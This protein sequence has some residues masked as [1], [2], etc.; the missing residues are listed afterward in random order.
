MKLLPIVGIDNTSHDDALT[1]GGKSPAYFMRDIVNFDISKRGSA[2]LRKSGRKVSPNIYLKVWQSPLHQ[3]VFAVDR[4]G[5]LLKIDPYSWE[6][7]QLGQVGHDVNFEVINNQ[8]FISASLGIFTFNGAVLTKITSDAPGYPYL[9][10]S[11][12]S[13]T[14]GQYGVAISYLRGTLESEL[15]RM[16]TISL[17]SDGLGIQVVLPLLKGEGVTGV[18]IYCTSGNGTELYLQSTHPADAVDVTIT[19]E[20]ELGRPASFR[21]FSKMPTGKFMTHW[22]GRLIT[23]DKNML[24]FSQSLTYH[25]TDPRYD[26]IRMPQSITF[27]IGVD[28]GLWVGQVDKVVFL[29]GNAPDTLSFEIK[30]AQPPVKGSA[31]TLDSEVTGE[32]GEGGGRTAMWLAANGLCIGTGSGGLIEPQSKRI[33]GI[34]AKSGG[35]VRFDRRVIATIK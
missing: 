9:Q 23:A 24:Y 28:G 16:E 32:L 12:G 19:G 26:Y 8:V 1:V 14:T 25:L 4:E 35:C 15:S 22:Q 11:D 3:D 13:L 34:S 29:R 20:A 30:T 5:Y 33:Q 17:E 7:K 27:V 31:I 2:H 10:K 21:Y 18:N 6:G